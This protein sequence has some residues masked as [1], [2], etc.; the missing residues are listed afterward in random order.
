[1]YSRNQTIDY[2]SNFLNGHHRTDEV[3]DGREEVEEK[4]LVKEWKRENYRNIYE[5][6]ERNEF[7]IIYRKITIYFNSSAET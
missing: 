6:T 3:R 2:R 1:M 5:Q 4:V 7:A